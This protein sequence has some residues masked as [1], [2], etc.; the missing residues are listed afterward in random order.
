M[1]L[2]R[3]LYMHGLRAGIHVHTI[4][5][6]VHNGMRLVDSS[7]LWASRYRE[8]EQH[9]MLSSFESKAHETALAKH[10]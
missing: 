9:W 10:C 2:F 6:L 3:Q 8:S 1:F 4:K 5:Q 7:E